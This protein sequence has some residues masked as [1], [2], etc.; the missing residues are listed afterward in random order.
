MKMRY[1][2]LCSLMVFTGVGAM[3]AGGGW[4]QSWAA[5]TGDAPTGKA[6]CR[7]PDATSNRSAVY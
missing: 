4:I 5:A 7:L 2:S 6:K 1:L 3:A